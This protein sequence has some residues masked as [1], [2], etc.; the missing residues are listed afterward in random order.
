MATTVMPFGRHQG[1]P[2]EDVPSDYLARVL[3][4]CKL[5]HRL[6]QA[7]CVELERRGVEAPPVPPPR[8]IGPCPQCGSSGLVLT[9]QQDRE[10]DR[11]IR[12]TC[13]ACGKFLCWAPQTPEHV[14]LADANAT[15][16]PILDALIE[17]ER[18][19]RTLHSDGQEC[20][21]END[22]RASPALRAAL[23]Q[24][25]HGLAAMLGKRTA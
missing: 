6:R 12:A 19:G 24:C 13:G 20:Q 11:R 5:S 25:N 14:Q 2:L 22:R 1:Q 10:G 9:W 8:P 16:A 3:K 15:P 21:L 17:A 4:T 23:R 7:V 18:L